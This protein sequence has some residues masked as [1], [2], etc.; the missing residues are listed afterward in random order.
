MVH[1]ATPRQ[2]EYF[3]CQR[4][5]ASIVLCGY[6]FKIVE[7]DSRYV[8]LHYK[9]ADLYYYVADS[10]PNAL[11]HLPKLSEIFKRFSY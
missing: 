2:S 11:A 4:L 10:L 7:A 5:A 1:L 9:G 8:V 6:Y 3:S